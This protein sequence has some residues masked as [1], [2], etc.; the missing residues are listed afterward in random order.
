MKLTIDAQLPPGLAARLREMGHD[1]D[2]VADDGLGDASDGRI[3][4]SVVARGAV[5]VTKDG[6]FAAR[7]RQ[8]PSSPGIIWI[9]FGNVGNRALWEKLAPLMKDI[10][11]AFRGGERI[12]EIR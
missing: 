11:R 10:E 3:W 6:D 7:A 8:S 1:A 4:D 2:H 5:L 12:V 9:R